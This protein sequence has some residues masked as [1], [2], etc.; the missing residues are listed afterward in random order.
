MTS[1]K[2]KILHAALQ[3]FAERG[4]DGTP[5]NLIAKTAG[6][7]EGLIFRHF[8]HKQ[9]LLEAIVEE[10]L[11]QIAQ[12]MQPYESGGDPRAAILAHI[13]LSVQLMQEQAIFWRLVQQLR[14]QPLV[15]S[16]IQPHVEAVNRF[17]MERL[18]AQF[19]QLGAAQPQLEAALLFALIDGLTIH[20]LQMPETYP[21]E[22]VAAL[23]KQKYTHETFLGK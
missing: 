21:L 14:F 4:Y 20:Y 7:S 2:E 6:V 18:T 22:A 8:Q 11:S 5:T 16:L 3:L 10:G 9:G 1:N 12:T 23:I 15:L 19:G 13:D 17:V